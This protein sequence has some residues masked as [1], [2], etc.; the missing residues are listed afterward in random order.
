MY[1]FGPETLKCHL[2]WDTP[3]PHLHIKFSLYVW[4]R[5]HGSQIFNR[6]SIISIRS[7]FIAFLRF[8]LLWLQEGGAGGWGVCRVIRVSLDEFRNVQR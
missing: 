8:R 3:P 6:N 2:G 4:K 7:C 5:A 1:F